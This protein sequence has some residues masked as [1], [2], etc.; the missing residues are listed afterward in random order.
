MLLAVASVVW[1]AIAHAEDCLTRPTLADVDRQLNA[2]EKAYVA[3]DVVVFANSAAEASLLLPCIGETI[4]PA[5]AANFHRMEGL[6][7]FGAGDE[8]AAL[9]SLR[10]ARVLDPRYRFPDD[11]LPPHHALREQY[12][13]LQ[14]AD[15]ATWRPPRP[16]HGSLAFDGVPSQLRPVGR[17]TLFQR[18][19]ASGVPATT[20]YLYPG[21]PTPRYPAVHRARNRLLAG[22]I[23]ATLVSGTFYA[24]AWSSRV[25][26]DDE[27]NVGATLHGL[28]ALQTQTQVF[29]G[30]AVGFLVLGAAGGTSAFLVSEQWD[31]H[32]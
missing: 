18:L 5:M 3:L 7:L 25:A 9:D 15:A 20:V 8:A 32:P 10:A 24:L 16:L 19:D 1:L 6:R 12:D 27:D 26:F 28:E 21:Q 22:G 13:A 31:P 29:S 23:G 17:A 11:V 30:L 2:A 14:M 4:T